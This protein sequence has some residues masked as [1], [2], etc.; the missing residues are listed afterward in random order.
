MEKTAVHGVH[1]GVRDKYTRVARGAAG[2]F[3]YATGRHGALALGYDPA[4][5]D[6]L[7]PDSMAAFCGVGNPWSLGLPGPGERILDVGCGAGVD[8]AV[9]ARLAGPTASAVGVDLTPEMADA[10]RRGLAHACVANA[11]VTAGSSE[12]LPFGDACFDRVVSNGVLNLS[13]DKEASFREIF[14]VLRPGG[15]L[16]FADIVRIGGP[17]T[18][19]GIDAWSD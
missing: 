1:R 2:F 19:C 17:P 8:V 4:W 9:A 3:G 13:P 6:G 12:A 7:G 18:H 11:S 15:R 5:L 14:R 16:Q 10:A